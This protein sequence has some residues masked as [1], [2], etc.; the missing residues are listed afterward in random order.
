MHKR[1]NQHYIL[2][3]EVLCGQ[4]HDDWRTKKALEVDKWITMFHNIS[5]AS[6]A[7]SRHIQRDVSAF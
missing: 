4:W 2:K 1:N 5:V 3:P 7:A 6:E